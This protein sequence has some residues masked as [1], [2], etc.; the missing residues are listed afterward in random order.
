MELALVQTARRQPDT[1]AVVHQDFHPVGP[2]VGKEVS[3]VRLRRTEHRNYSGQCRFSAGA[4]VHGF[5]GKPDGINAN[6]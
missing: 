4:H 6:H 5:G 1:D 2:P 3:A